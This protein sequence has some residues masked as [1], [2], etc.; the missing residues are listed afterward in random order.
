MRKI[1]LRVYLPSKGIE[2]ALMT[3]FR[4]QSR[5]KTGPKSLAKRFQKALQRASK[6]DS[7]WKLQKE[8]AESSAGGAPTLKVEDFRPSWGRET[9]R[10]TDSIVFTRRT[11]LGQAKGS[12]DLITQE[13]RIRRSVL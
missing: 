1:R 2:D 10:G 13:R 8:A 6:E 4:S 7:I 9:G 12:A 5:R 3:D 11:T